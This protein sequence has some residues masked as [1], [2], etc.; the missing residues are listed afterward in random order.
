MIKI[1]TK[2]NKEE[3][4]SYLK[5]INAYDIFFLPEYFEIN[6]LIFKGTTECFL[7]YENEVFILYPYIRRSI[8]GSEF[9]DITSAYGY[10]GY[11]GSPRNSGIVNFRAAFHKYC[12]E[13]RIVSEFIRFHPL[14]GN[15]ILDDSENGT[16][17]SCQPVVIADLCC[18]ITELQN[19]VKKKAREKIRKA[20]KN[21]IKVYAHD[22]EDSYK[23]F[24]KL[25]HKT[26][27]RLNASNFYFFDDNFFLAIIKHLGQFSKLFLAWHQGE[28]VGGLLLIHGESF[29]Y[30][31]LS[32]SDDRYGKLGVKDLL[33]WKILEWSQGKGK[34]KHLLG[35]G[36]KGEDS[37]FRFKA[38]FSPN[39]ENYYLGKI[40]HL[41]GTY[42]KLCERMNGFDSMKREQSGSM[43][44]FP[45]YRGLDAD[46]AV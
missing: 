22:D 38:K 7:Y 16:V 11:I 41:T 3:W 44:W 30:N 26:M 19:K 42:A 14:Y 2:K 29:S 46:N 24:M 12:I 10:G 37:L 17:V 31:F 18:D 6:E 15:H 9:F 23:Q 27:A 8:S 25:Y 13:Q 43:E 45:Y 28:L 39:R 4:H 33:Q 21:E 35:G 34:K 5:N 20:E 1:L 36:R 32:C 40:I